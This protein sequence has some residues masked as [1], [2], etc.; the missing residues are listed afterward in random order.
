MPRR[1]LGTISRPGLRPSIGRSASVFICATRISVFATDAAGRL[2]VRLLPLLALVPEH[3]GRD[4]AE[5]DDHE[6]QHRAQD[7]DHELLLDIQMHEVTAHEVRLD[8]RDT[9]G[10]DQRDEPDADH[11]AGDTDGDER[12]Q[13]RPNPDVV[14]LAVWMDA[15][16]RVLRHG[17]HFAMYSKGNRKIQTTSTKCQ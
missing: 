11:W 8:D 17:R 10:R 5:E 1:L 14:A 6:C 9:E 12:A 2:H 15:G 16:V 7:V 13:D 4:A 3:V